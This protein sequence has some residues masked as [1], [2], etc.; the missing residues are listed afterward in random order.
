[1]SFSV[2]EGL[3]GELGEGRTIDR[4]RSA[5]NSSRYKTIKQKAIN[6]T[7]VADSTIARR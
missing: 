5:V 3:D 1:M 2:F 7:S 4:W 6:F